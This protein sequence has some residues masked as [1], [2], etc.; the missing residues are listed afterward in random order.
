MPDAGFNRATLTSPTVEPRRP[1]FGGLGALVLVLVVAAAGLVG[2]KIIQSGAPAVAAA[3][4][5]RNLAKI[6]Q[7]LTSMEQ[8]LDRLERRRAAAQPSA[9]TSQSKASALSVSGSSA[10]RASKKESAESSEPQP[11]A[12]SR[13][14]QTDVQ[15]Q[16]EPAPQLTKAS[17]TSDSV[18]SSE[19]W[20][21]TANQLSDVVGV[22]GSQQDELSKTQEEVGRLAAQTQR[23]AVPFQ[24]RR[25]SRPQVVGPV[26]LQLKNTD[27]HRQRYSIDVFLDEK[28]VEFKDRAVDELVDFILPGQSAPM[29]FVATRINHDSISGY[30]EVPSRATPR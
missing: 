14:P 20:Q 29:R 23:F 25:G 24:L 11:A 1:G 21:A 3:Q 2:Y 18:A 19:A 8:R 6:Q 28:P 15:A 26:S 12:L 17:S 10:L 27:E 13:T 30:M 16:T 9:V 4:Q 7:Q 5:D 22:V